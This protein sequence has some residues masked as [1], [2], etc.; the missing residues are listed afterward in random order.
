M[1]FIT[2]EYFV[3]TLNLARWKELEE[4]ELYINRAIARV[5]SF[6]NIPNFD[7]SK[8][9]KEQEKAINDCVVEFSLFFENNGYDLNNNSQSLAFGTQ[10]FSESRTVDIKVVENYVVNLLKKNGLILDQ[11]G[12]YL[13]DFYLDKQQASQA[14]NIKTIEKLT[15]QV[16]VLIE[17]ISKNNDIN[18]NLKDIKELK[19]YIDKYKA[20]KNS[21]LDKIKKSGNYLKTELDGSEEFFIGRVRLLYFNDQVFDITEQQKNEFENKYFYF[22]KKDNKYFLEITFKQKNIRKSYLE[23]NFQNYYR[24]RI[25]NATTKLLNYFMNIIPNTEVKVQVSLYDIAENGFADFEFGPDN[26]L[27]VWINK[28]PEQ[29]KTEKGTLT[30]TPSTTHLLTFKL[31]YSELDK[32]ELFE[33]FE[34]LI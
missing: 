1:E 3:N 32:N 12:N 13:N 26:I 17:Q 23:Y 29:L 20:N 10:S 7:I 14:D 24:Y 2:R 5:L 11:V 28:T 8:I 6:I 30:K 25:K 21:F 19:T 31:I 9:N 27:K 22:Y 34:D 15:Q 18:E 33:N 16:D 4:A